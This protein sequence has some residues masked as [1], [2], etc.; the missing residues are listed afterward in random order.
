MGPN[1]QEHNTYKQQ[2][3]RQTTT[4]KHVQEINPQTAQLKTTHAQ[5][6]N[7]TITKETPVLKMD[8]LINKQTCS[9][10]DSTYKQT[11]THAHEHVGGII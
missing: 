4:N 9:E 5:H 6:M 8:T 10:N 7:P 3:A 11:H 1:I 2:H